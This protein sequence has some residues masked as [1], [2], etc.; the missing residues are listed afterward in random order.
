MKEYKEHKESILFTA[1]RPEFVM[2]YGKGMYLFDT[3]GKKYLDFIGGWAVNCLGHSSP[4][5]TQA[6]CK[7]AV[8]LI[9][10]SPSFYNKPMLEFAK[11]LTDISCFD[12]V[13]FINSGAEAN[14]GAIKLARKYGAKQKNGAYEIITT[15]NGFHGRTLATMSASGKKNWDNL[16][17]P[18]VDG[19]IH[20][21]FNDI[22]SIEEAVTSNTCAIMIEPVQGEGGVNIADKEYI[23]A[24]RKL[25]DEK[26]ILLIFDEIQTGV[27]R[28]GTMFAYQQ[29]EIEP[30][31]MTLAK[32]IGGGYPLAAVLA[33]E[34]LNIFEAGDQ[35]GT[36][37]SQPLGMSVGY[38]V[39]HEVSVNKLY[40]HANEMGIYII[41]QLQTIAE[42]YH[43][44]NIRGKGLLIAFDLEGDQAVELVNLCLE[45]G[46]IINA[47]KPH[48]IRLIPPLIVTKHEIDNMIVLLKKCLG[49]LQHIV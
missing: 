15:I 31:I 2:Q 28:C 37:S 45:Q 40:E 3:L 4:V 42:Q 27:G 22:Q 23:K 21:P 8:E 24:I 38:A 47:P 25:C 13:F 12:R 1:N 34:Y 30:D 20:V 46:L 33:K 9:N 11:L 19:F 36:Y 16:F 7:Q 43:L 39:V 44:S 48:I 26:N 41:M 17:N 5:I 14:E 49:A 32:G 29:Y 18:K 6:L 10:C 35:G